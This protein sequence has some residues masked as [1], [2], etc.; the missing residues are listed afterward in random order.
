[1]K[2][3]FQMLSKYSVLLKL[4]NYSQCYVF[5]LPSSILHRSAL[6]R[7]ATNTYEQTA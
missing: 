1:M 5:K 6:I 4:G 3:G 2:D 7:D